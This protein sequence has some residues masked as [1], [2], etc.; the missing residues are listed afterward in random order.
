M[1]KLNILFLNSWYPN[2]VFPANGNFIQQHARAVALNCNIACLHVEVRVQKELF[3]ITKSFNEGVFEVIVYVKKVESNYSFIKKLHRRHLAYK[4]GLKIINEKFVK[5]DVT[6][7]NVVLPAGLFAIYLKTK[8]KIPFIITEHSTT[9]LKSSGSTHRF[10][11]RFLIKK[12]VQKASK[13]CPVS[14]DLKEAMIFSGYQGD[15]A[16][17]PNVVNTSYFKYQ[18]KE[19]LKKINILHVSSLKEEHK[20][21]RGILRVM[22][23]LSQRRQDFTFTMISDGDTLPIKKYAEE[24]ELESSLFSLEGAKPAEGIALAMQEYDLFLLFSNYENL[25]CVISESLVSGMPVISSDVGGISEMI[26]NENGVLVAAGNEGELL[27]KLEYVINN[28]SKFNRSEIAI[29]AK[30][31]FSYETVGAQFFSIYKEIIKD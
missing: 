1:K 22:K 10:L 13:V 6:H 29:N 26:T 27:C 24:I 8:F 31:T 9:Y 16:V 5:V 18:K 2:A 3:E 4:K 20:N 11:E 14:N 7:L 25:P 21:G 12:V 17:I 23:K 15:Y 30:N 28:I 19:I